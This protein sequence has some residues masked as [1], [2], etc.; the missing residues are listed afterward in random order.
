MVREIA[1][2]PVLARGTVDV[3][4]K[5]SEEEDQR[6]FC[7]SAFLRFSITICSK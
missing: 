1:I 3:C 7:T 2:L 6:D 4:E 5:S